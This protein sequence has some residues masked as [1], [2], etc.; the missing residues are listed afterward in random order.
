MRTTIGDIPNASADPIKQKIDQLVDSFSTV[1][2]ERFESVIQDSLVLP[3]DQPA[4]V[5]YLELAFRGKFDIL[6]IEKQI[7]ADEF[8]DFEPWL[9]NHGLA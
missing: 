4:C 2:R 5:S 1:L 9:A 7:H 3:K 8:D 6:W